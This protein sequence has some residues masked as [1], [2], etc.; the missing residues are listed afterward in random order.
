MPTPFVCGRDREECEE[1]ERKEGND[2]FND[3]FNLRDEMGEGRDGSLAQFCPQKAEWSKFPRHIHSPPPPTRKAGRARAWA[4]AAAS[5]R[6]A[7]S[8]GVLASHRLFHC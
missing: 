5:R 7:G 6:K 4:L 2:G 1:T 8:L 3:G